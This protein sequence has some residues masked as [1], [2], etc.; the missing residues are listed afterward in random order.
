MDLGAGRLYAWGKTGLQLRGGHGK[1]R[2]GQKVQRG[3]NLSNHAQLLTQLSFGSAYTV[4]PPYNDMG[5]A[6]RRIVIKGV[7]LYLIF[8]YK[9]HPKLK[10][11]NDIISTPVK[12]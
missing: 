4:N 5:F 2:R 7:L 8:V 12:P 3:H 10:L 11:G 6:A 1:T 9:I